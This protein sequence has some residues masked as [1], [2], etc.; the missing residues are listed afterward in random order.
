MRAALGCA[1]TIAIAAH[2]AAAQPAAT[3]TAGIEPQSLAGALNDFAT[4]TGLQLIYVSRIV[5]AERS[6]GAPG[7]LPPHEAL[8]R[9]L[10]GTGLAFAFLNDR[11]VRIYVPAM[12]PHARS[13]PPPGADYAGLAPLEE[14]VVNASRRMEPATLSPVSATVWTEQA[15]EF[16]GVKGIEEIG[17]L[18]PGVGF[19][20]N[21][22]LGDYFTGLDIRGV[23]EMHGNLTT[24]IFNDT[25]L[26]AG[27]GETYLR[28]YPFAFDLDRIEV[29]RGPQGG[30]L[31]EDT[32]SGAVHFHSNEPSLSDFS[33]QAHTELATT[34]RGAPSYEAGVAAGG[35]I[36]PGR[37]GFRASGWYRVDGGYIDRVDPFTGAVVDDDS[38]RVTRKSARVALA[39]APTDTVRIAPELIIQ[40]TNGDDVSSFLVSLS[41]PDGGVL[42]NG[43]QIAQPWDDEL[44][45][46]SI[47]VTAETGSFDVWTLTSYY[48]ENS[49]VILDA[50]GTEFYN[51]TPGYAHLNQEVFSQEARLSSPDPDARIRWS[52][53]FGYWD[54]SVRET[55]W[56]GDHLE[57]S[58]SDTL[59]KYATFAVT[60]EVALRI[61]NR[62]TA[63]AGLRVARANYDA[64]T[65]VEPTSRVEHDDSYA[66]PNLGLTYE[67]GDTGSVYLIAAKGYRAGGIYAPI[68]GCG[69]LDGPVPYPADDLWSYELGTKQNGLLDGRVELDAG[70]YYM[71]WAHAFEPPSVGC[72]A[73]SYLQPSA[74][75]SKGLNFASRLFLNDRLRFGLSVAYMNAY[76]SKTTG[77]EDAPFAREGDPL[78]APPWTVTASIEGDVP[79]GL[80]IASLRA[81]YTYRRADDG[82]SRLQDPTSP[83]YDPQFRPEPSTR[84]LNLRAVIA[85]KNLEAALFV[86]NALDAQPMLGR[87]HACCDDPFYTAS[88]FRPRTVG[89]SA[90]WRL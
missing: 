51:P 68:L 78:G 18:T 38:N 25:Q 65:L 14:V 61:S 54:R 71:Q 82:P 60:G 27:R 28:L 16:A 77:P 22:R 47:R 48:R 12:R 76:Y 86:T 70:A 3:L 90:T 58:D 69:N 15:M 29:L 81:D 4:Q 35:P 53:G 83:D 19:S 89:L 34:A 17:A 6:A 1:A 43:Y 64:A 42:K 32:L 31:L 85:W 39:W 30:R 52:A 87:A 20:Y 80:A 66:T 33:G 75:V 8:G 26:L 45:L 72:I 44:D 55:S 11:T 46:A 56:A 79:L 88:T 67:S 10:E 73:L 36:D 7:G 40:S 41:D 63:N 62:L 21:S 23:S 37:F 50:S 5:A 2:S 13:P 57:G 9:L 59:S 84:A 49:H 74:A 24:L